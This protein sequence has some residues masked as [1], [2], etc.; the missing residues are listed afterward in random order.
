[1][2]GSIVIALQDLVKSKYGQENWTNILKKSNL[3]KDKVFYGHH[4]IEDNIVMT[5]IQNTCEVLGVTLEQAAEA[6]GNYWM[7]EY[8]PKKYFAF[9]AG[10]KTA[11]E[12]LL[13]MNRLHSKITDRI[14]NARPPKFEYEE[15]TM[16]KQ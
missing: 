3:P 11:K 5:L 9:F 16:G 13:E 15:L 4:D 12:F 1:M 14:E 2:K 7:N 8:A 10:K 6:F